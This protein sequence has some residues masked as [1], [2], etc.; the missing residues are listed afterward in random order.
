[1]CLYDH[2]SLFRCEEFT[3]DLCPRILD[4]ACWSVSPLFCRKRTADKISIL[5]GNQEDG[6]VL[7]ITNALRDRIFPT[8]L[9]YCKN[10]SCHL[11]T[12]YREPL[13]E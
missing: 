10:C 9:G 4:A 2:F 5:H 7:R 8:C 12:Y 6:S 11:F 3:S 13:V 1:M